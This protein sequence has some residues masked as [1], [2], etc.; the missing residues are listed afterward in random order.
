MP[1]KKTVTPKAGQ[2]QLRVGETVQLATYGKLFSITRQAIINDDLS[3]FTRIPMNMARAAKRTVGNLVYAILTGNPT[4]ADGIALF[5]ASS[6]GANLGSGGG[7]V[8]AVAGLSAGRV[9]MMKQTGANSEALNIQ[10]SYLIVPVA[11]MDTAR[12]T[13]GSEFDPD[14]ANKIQRRNPVAGMCEVVAEARLDA[15]SAT[16]WYLA[17]DPNMFDTIEVQY[18]DGNDAPYLE[19][20]DGWNVDGVEMKVRIDAGVKALDYRTLYKSAGA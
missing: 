6:H 18:L 13:V 3:A 9:I 4:M 20:K 16:A 5:H 7:S 11:L 2:R 1:R 19:Q 8:L 15:A 12:V 14:T 17:A 10:P